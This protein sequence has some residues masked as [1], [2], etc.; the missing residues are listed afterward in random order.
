MLGLDDIQHLDRTISAGIDPTPVPNAVID[1]AIL[2]TSAQ[3]F[4][5][6]LGGGVAVS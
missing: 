2:A 3:V 1:D 5:K 6:G 4:A